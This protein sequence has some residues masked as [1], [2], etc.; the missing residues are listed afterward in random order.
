M[1]KLDK[2]INN[3]EPLKVNEKEI[4]CLRGTYIDVSLL[5]EQ[6][7]QEI[8]VNT[9]LKKDYRTLNMLGENSIVELEKAL[10]LLREQNK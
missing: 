7:L 6:I 9:I 8:E 3:A 2:I 1:D 10:E 4:Y 5:V